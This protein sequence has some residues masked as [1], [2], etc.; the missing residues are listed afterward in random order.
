MATGETTIDSPGEYGS[1]SRGR[2]RKS[3]RGRLSGIRRCL[4]AFLLAVAVVATG[5]GDYRPTALEV[6]TAPHRYSIAGW[7]LDHLSHKWT[8]QLLK[9]LPL[10]N[11][12]SR[13]EQ[14][15]LVENFFQWGAQQRQMESSL[16]RAR[17]DAQGPGD[18]ALDSALDSAP[19][20]A[21]DSA[22]DTSLDTALERNR[23]RRREL[24]PEVE[25]IVENELS[26]LLAREGFALRWIGVFPP[27]DVVFGTPPAVLVLSPRDR[28]YRQQAVLLRPGLDDA[29]KERL[30]RVALETQDLSAVV[31]RTGGLSVYPSVVLDTSGL[32]F[33]LES[34]AH[35]WVHH[36][37]FFRPLGRNYG[38]SPEMLT[39]N[40]TA[41]TIAGEELGDLVYASLTGK[42]AALPPESA[43]SA[44]SAAAG[45]FD[46][47]GE[48]RETRRRAEELLAEG[49]ID[50]AEA[51]ME[52]R[53]RLFVARGYN[54][55]KI[56]Q[57]YFAFYGSYAT[58]P[59]SVSPIGQQMRD[60]RQQSG[61]LKEFLDT[62][63]QF[64]SYDEY[65][66]F[67]KARGHEAPR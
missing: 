4:L 9:L 60:L 55:R 58:G 28:I 31:E 19:D 32:R 39:L 12:L 23:E 33:A 18:S 37:L 63:A 61:S 3:S 45:R 52:E 44:E 35:E 57:A 64:G 48:M 5:G 20:S 66:E 17:L 21:L 38:K 46:F 24:L 51:Y 16:L 6:E 7:E 54:I 42:E 47:T 36:W 59:G 13:E 56:N 62:V 65:L 40:E 30:E 41:A 43:Q 67:W 8:R 10:L 2:S 15:S 1:P 29:V 11:D 34:A 27:V 14:A 50:G 22:L 25:S 49:D 53:R 26:R